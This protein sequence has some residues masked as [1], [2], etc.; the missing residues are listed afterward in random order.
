M[1]NL[2]FARYQMALTLGFHIIFAAIGIAMPFFMA[3]S[4]WIYLKKKDETH[5]ILTK[6]WSRGVA[7]FFAVG[8][9]SGTALAFELGLL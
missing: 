6:A 2:L 9:V 3:A 8:A 7:I 4:H 1:S 5:L